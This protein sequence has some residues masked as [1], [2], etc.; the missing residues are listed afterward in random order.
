MLSSPVVVI[1][2]DVRSNKVV[3]PLKYNFQTILMELQLI[4][5]VKN[6][7]AQMR[8]VPLSTHHL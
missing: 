3:V 2:V 7:N 5:F 1:A 4:L 6:Y 8:D